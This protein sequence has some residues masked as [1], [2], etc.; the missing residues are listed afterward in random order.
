MIAFVNGIVKI[1]RNDR[2]VLDVHGVG[3]EVYLANALSQKM[4]EELFL[5][6]YQHVRED[7][8]LL[9]GFIKEEDYEVFMRLI[10]VKGIGPKTAQTM[11]S[12]CSGKEMI[13]A[14]ENDDIKRLKSLPGIGAKTA[15]Q[16]VLDLKGKFVSLETSDSPV[17]NPVWTQVQDALLSLGYKT[18]Q[19]TKIKKE[20]ENTELGEDEM[21]RQALILLAK[22]NGV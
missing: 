9:F 3:Y 5:Y 2:V 13:E 12:V 22:R 18:N 4:N 15:G 19:L 8:I 17:S 6:T 10:N 11:L 1:I 20:F 14:I 7:A 21:L 16:I